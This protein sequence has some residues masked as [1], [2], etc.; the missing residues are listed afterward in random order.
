MRSKAQNTTQMNET[1]EK[2]L[3]DTLERLHR[4]E[5]HLLVLQVLKFTK[6]SI[7]TCI[8]ILQGESNTFKSEATKLE[9]MNTDLQNTLHSTVDALTQQQDINSR[10]LKEKEEFII[11]FDT[12]QRE[13]DRYLL[14]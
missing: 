14:C 11:S 3:S 6:N 12:I 2:Q 8:N 7:I 1:L 10:L 13:R 4:A 9:M 5:N